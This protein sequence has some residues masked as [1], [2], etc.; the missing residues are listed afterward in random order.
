MP[1]DSQIDNKRTRMKKADGKTPITD[2]E[3]KN[4]NKTAKKQSVKHNDV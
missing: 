2:E 1:K 3:V 4:K